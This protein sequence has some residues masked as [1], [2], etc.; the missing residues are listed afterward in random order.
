[1]WIYALLFLFPAAWAVSGRRTAA[2]RPAASVVV[3]TAIVLAL[4]IGLRFRVGGD[5][6]AYWLM[7][8]RAHLHD[9]ATALTISDPAYM[10]LNVLAARLGLS[11]A[12]VNLICAVLTAAGAI[13]FSIRQPRPWLALLIAC[14][15]CSP[16]RR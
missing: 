13:L 2:G 6:H 9:A 7:L 5:W 11:I 16:L 8:E 1:M 12:F 14:R 4:F 3:I 10:A 15:C